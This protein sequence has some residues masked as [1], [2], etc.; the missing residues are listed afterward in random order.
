MSENLN[1]RRSAKTR[2]ALS[3]A[4]AELLTQKELRRITVQEIADKAEVNRVTFYKHYLDVYDLYEKLEKN[5]LVDLGLLILRL[6]ELPSEQAFA[7]LINYISDNRPVFCMM[8]SP[9]STCQLRDKFAKITEGLF[10]QME[11]EKIAAMDPKKHEYLTCYRAQ[12][13]LAVI[14]K[15]V[16]EGFVVPKDTLIKSI[17]LLDKSIDKLIGGN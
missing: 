10:L 14:A 8:F 7:E 6:E 3:N 11:N 13:C 2:R 5:L 12:G 1:D 15:W 17:S 4:M 16:N 9:N